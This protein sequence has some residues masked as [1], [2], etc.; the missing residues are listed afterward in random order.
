MSRF[1]S[2]REAKLAIFDYVEAF[3]NRCRRHTAIGMTSP[4]QF[5]QNHRHLTL[6]A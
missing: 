4:E 6:A 3:Y 1:T 5:E 2:H